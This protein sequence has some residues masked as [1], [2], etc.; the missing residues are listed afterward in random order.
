MWRKKGSVDDPEHGGGNV[1]AWPCMAASGTGWLIFIDDVTDGG[2]SRMNSVVYR[3]ILSSNL[4]RNAS[5]LVG[6][7]FVMQQDNDPKHTANITKGLH[8]GG[9]MEGFRLAEAVT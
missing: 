7:R 8:R 9:K 6:R 2:S 3:N 5:R 4:Q 1:M